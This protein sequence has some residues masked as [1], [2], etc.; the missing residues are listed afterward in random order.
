MT[1]P[2]RFHHN[3]SS[4]TTYAE[5]AGSVICCVISWPGVPLNTMEGTNRP[6]TMA[7]IS[8]TPKNTGFFHLCSKKLVM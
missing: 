7:E 8:G 4:S 5:G 1:K 2:L 6:S 3:I